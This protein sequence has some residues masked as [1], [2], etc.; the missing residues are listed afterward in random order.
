MNG[1]RLTPKHGFP[2]RVVVPGV[3]GARSVKWLDQ[4]TVSTKESPNFYQ[5]RDYKILPPNVTDKGSAAKYWDKVPPMMDNVINSVVAVPEDEETVKRS[6]QGTI[7]TKGYAIPQGDGGPVVKVEVSTDNGETWTE[8]KLGPA[9]RY[10]WVLWE[11]VVAIE[12]GKGKRI[13]SKATDRQGNTQTEERSQWNLRGVG[14]Q[15]YESTT[16]LTVL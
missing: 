3:I 11:A 6:P 10:S 2:V 14:Y 1:E 5:Q 16:G 7:S 9:T 12:R 8:A 13:F 15:G 4:I